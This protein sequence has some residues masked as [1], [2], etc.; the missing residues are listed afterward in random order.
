M[1]FDTSSPPQ[2]VDTIHRVSHGDPIGNFIL[3]DGT[4]I[5]ISAQAH[6]YWALMWP[7]EATPVRG[8]TSSPT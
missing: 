5:V 8:R 3:D 6:Q 2:V 7:E 4:I 1:R